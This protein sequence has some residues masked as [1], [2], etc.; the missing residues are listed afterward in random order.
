MDSEKPANLADQ[1]IAAPVEPGAMS[2]EEY[3]RE[4]RKLNVEYVANLHALRASYAKATRPA[5]F[6][7]NKAL[8]ALQ[9]LD[10]IAADKH[11]EVSTG[12][13]RELPAE[14]ALDGG[15]DIIIN[16]VHTLPQRARLVAP[17][18]TNRISCTSAMLLQ[19]DTGKYP[20]LEDHLAG[21]SPLYETRT[22]RFGN[23]VAV[24]VETKPKQ[25]EDR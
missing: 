18:D 1:K 21:R 10:S 2:A 25:G 23:T 14:P 17:S 12:G 4:A 8:E 6:A 15:A 20:T 19:M 24:P 9:Q 16:D 7:Q 22:N 13:V 11:L 5:P 3:L